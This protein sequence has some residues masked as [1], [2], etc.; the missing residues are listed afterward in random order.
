MRQWYLL[1]L[2]LPSEATQS[3]VSCI[4]SVAGEAGEAKT[5]LQ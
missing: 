4:S 1:S 3:R 5:G 2:L